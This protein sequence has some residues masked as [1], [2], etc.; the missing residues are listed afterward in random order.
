MVAFHGRITFTLSRSS[1][2]RLELLVP[3]HQRYIGET[4]IQYQ[5]VGCNGL[6]LIME[7]QGE[8]IKRNSALVLL[9]QHDGKPVMMAARA[10][11]LPAGGAARSGF[12]VGFAPS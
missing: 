11:A 8:L 7:H 6:R 5:S 4:L 12:H 1:T 10:F 3:E 9:R 2:R